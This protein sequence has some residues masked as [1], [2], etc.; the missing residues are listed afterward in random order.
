MNLI[1]IKRFALA[2]NYPNPFNPETTIEFSLD[3]ANDVTLNVYSIT[4]QLVRTLINHSMAAGDHTVN[5][6]GRDDLGQALSS[7]VYFY[8]LQSG[9][10]VA[11]NKMI[12]MK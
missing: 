5:F 4:G 10:Q 11:T 7:G 3:K 8:Q 1:P 2:N 6:N 12:L 9:E